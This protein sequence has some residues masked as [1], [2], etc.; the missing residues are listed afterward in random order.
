M[1]EAELPE[2]WD[3]VPPTPQKIR[4]M[5]PVTTPAKSSML[6]LASFQN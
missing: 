4:A 1:H 5:P 3:S 6:W 2:G